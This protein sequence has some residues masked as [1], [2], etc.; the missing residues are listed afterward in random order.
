MRCFG[1]ANEIYIIDL[2][3]NRYLKKIELPNWP[4]SLAISKDN[5]YLAVATKGIFVY[6]FSDIFIKNELELTVLK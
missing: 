2:K 6:S 5:N 3:D 1:G 4:L